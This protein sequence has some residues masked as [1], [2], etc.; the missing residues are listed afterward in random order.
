MDQKIS[1]MGDQEVMSSFHGLSGNNDEALCDTKLEHCDQ[2]LE[3]NEIDPSHDQET[4]EI[5]LEISD[6][7]K[8][9]NLAVTGVHSDETL[10]H[11][12]IKEGESNHKMESDF[13]SAQGSDDIFEIRNQEPVSNYVAQTGVDPGRKIECLDMKHNIDVC[14]VNCDQGSNIKIQ[15]SVCEAQYD[16]ITE[17]THHLNMHLQEPDKCKDKICD[18]SEQWKYDHDIQIP[19]VVNNVEYH[20]SLTKGDKEYLGGR[21]AS[22]EPKLFSCNLCNKS[23]GIKYYLNQHVKQVHEKLKP[24]SCTL[25]K[26]SFAQ[27]GVLTRHVNAVHNKLKP[28]S[29]TLCDKSFNQKRDLI[30]H[31]DEVHYKLRPFSCTLCDESFARTRLLAQHVNSVHDNLKPFNCSLCDKSYAYQ[32]DLIRH[33]KQVHHKVKSAQSGGGTM[34]FVD[35]PSSQIKSHQ[36]SGCLSKTKSQQQ[37][38][39]HIDSSEIVPK[40]KLRVQ[41]NQHHLRKLEP[42]PGTSHQKAIGCKGDLTKDTALEHDFTHK[43][44]LPIHAVHKKPKPLSCTLC[45]KSFKSKSVLNI[46]MDVYHRE[47][48]TCKLCEKSFSHKVHLSNHIAAVHDKSFPCTLCTKSF[49][50]KDAV[51]RHVDAVHNKLK[52]F[53]CT[54]CDKSFAEKGTLTRHVDLIHHKIKSFSCTLCGKSFMQ[55][56]NL[57][58]HVNNVHSKMKPFPCTLCNNS[59]GS[60]GDLNKHTDLEHGLFMTCTFC[61]KSFALRENLNDHIAAE[62]GGKTF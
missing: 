3:N 41:V 60:K 18:I 9:F 29:C 6:Q 2:K 61:D 19:Q 42:F 44:T 51:K 49:T 32:T 34:S 21:N 7:K 59:F 23:F 27:R 10:Q 50:T 45:H 8:M 33:V 13:M 46:H 4:F 20:G 38:D 31:I 54:L 37:N 39:S 48:F 14:N 5:K 28:F 62:H 15:C 56:G 57:T 52:P 17:Y 43:Q 16:N 58:D 30:K 55:K 26:K 40:S 11:Q 53:T 22:H 35:L 24:F 1:T 36:N 12:F 47:S 25:C